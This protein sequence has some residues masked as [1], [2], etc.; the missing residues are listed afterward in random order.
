MLDRFLIEHCSPTLAG[1]KA[2]NLFRCFIS[3]SEELREQLLMLN[4]KLN[5]K[6]LYFEVLSENGRS[7]LILVY[8]R[9]MLQNQLDKSGVSEF[10]A[11]YGYADQSVEYCIGRLKSR[12]SENGEFPHEI[13]IFA[14]YPLE[15]VIGFIRNGGRNSKITGCWKVYHNE[16]EAARLFYKF[17][18]CKDIYTQLF[19]VGRSIV[20]LTVAA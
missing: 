17:Q 7:A 12:F 14:G 8:R 20:Q 13:G 9:R 10:L 15:D 11:A 18:K 1:L 19:S 3:S 4:G 16:G 5:C 2:A 6:G